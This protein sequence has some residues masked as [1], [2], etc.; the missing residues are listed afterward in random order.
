MKYNIYILSLIGF[1][2]TS[3]CAYG[4]TNF[5]KATIIVVNE[6]NKP[7]DGAYT[8]ITFESNTGHGTKVSTDDGSS[9]SEGKFTATGSCNGHISY[10]GKKEG[11]YDSYYVY[12]FTNRNAFGWEPCNSS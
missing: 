11:Y 9:D 1:I 12:D 4:L 3:S 10:G 7:I 6:N 5:A 2:L 8:G